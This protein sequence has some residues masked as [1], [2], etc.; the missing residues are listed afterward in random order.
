MKRA[1]LVVLTLSLSACTMMSPAANYTFSK[2]PA[3]A[4]LNSSGTLS[5]KKDGA[6]TLTSASLSGLTP[7]TY[8]VAHYHQQ[9]TASTTPCDS[10]GAPIMSSMIVGQTDAAGMLKL[11][12]S[13]TSAD[14][15]SATYF[16]V[17]T[18]KDASGAPA[19][20]GVMCASVKM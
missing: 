17:H 18:A 11:S 16:N 3:G 8:Y 5:V 13:V 9:G 10:G 7:N 14:I 4:S 2:Q 1:A 19:D 12:G 20:G 6:M 15:A